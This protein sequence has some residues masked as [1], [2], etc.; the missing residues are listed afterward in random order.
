M[1][2]NHNFKELKTD[3]T[4]NASKIDWKVDTERILNFFSSGDLYADKLTAIRELIQNAVDS[5]AAKIDISITNDLLTIDDDGEGMSYEEIEKYLTT[6]GATTKTGA[7]TIGYY[8][9]GFLASLNLADTVIVDTAKNKKGSKILITPKKNLIKESK[10]K[11]GTKVY[12]YGNFLEKEITEY[13]IRVCGYLKVPIFING[14]K[15]NKDF[16]SYNAIFTRSV[17]NEGLEGI[18]GIKKATGRVSILQKRLFVTKEDF[19][20]ISGVINYD[21]LK[22]TGSRDDIEKNEEFLK[23][24]EIITAEAILMYRDF[25]KTEQKD[26]YADEIIRF[27][28]HTNTIEL[29]ENLKILETIDDKR[30]TPLEVIDIINTKKK[31]V[32]CRERTIEAD[33]AKAQGYVVVKIPQRRSEESVCRM[34]LSKYGVTMPWFSDIPTEKPIPTKILQNDELKDREK[35]F[36]EIANS[37]SDHNIVFG[38][39][40]EKSIVA[41]NHKEKGIQQI[42]FNIDCEE[43]RE[44]IDSIY[45]I[46]V[47]KALLIPSLAHEEAHEKFELHKE[48]FFYEMEEIIQQ[49]I[50]K[51][52]NEYKSYD[53]TIKDDHIILPKELNASKID[54]LWGGK[55]LILIL[56]EINIELHAMIQKKFKNQGHKEVSQ[57]EEHKFHVPQEIRGNLSD[58]IAVFSRKI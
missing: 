8:G 11:R 14:K 19:T 53:L 28:Y 50:T 27:I 57:T 55:S 41:A 1:D 26:E 16:T 31:V 40:K 42:V 34:I 4:N 47:I 17:D 6:I 5:D 46:D 2:N 12:G 21:K 15:I 33:I 49:K 51:L 10:R 22:V 23:L 3:F 52:T 18:I 25:I 30:F 9:I 44:I 32:F 48:D 35:L 54:F 29:A 13:I 20:S 45:N 39:F 56:A 38:T 7:D 24:E 43:N 37:I 36:L 58:K